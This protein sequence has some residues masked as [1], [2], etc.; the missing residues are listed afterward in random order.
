M[1]SQRATMIRRLL[2][3]SLHKQHMSICP[4]LKWYI[5]KYNSKCAHLKTIY[6]RDLRGES[7]LVIVVEDQ[8]G[9]ELIKC[10][11]I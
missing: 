6:I 5:R 10:L 9:I 11:N 2:L 1:N 8:Q 7:F 4:V 3:N